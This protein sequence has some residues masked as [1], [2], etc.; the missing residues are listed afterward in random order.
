MLKVDGGN[1]AKG[2]DWEHDKDR[3]MFLIY[4]QGTH[5]NHLCLTYANVV[6]SKRNPVNS[7]LSAGRFVV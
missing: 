7:M 5:F 1:K 3:Y 6:C 2:N 4:T